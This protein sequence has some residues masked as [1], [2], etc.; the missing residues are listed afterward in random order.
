MKSSEFKEGEWV[1]FIPPQAKGDHR[2][3]DCLRGLV[4]STNDT[5][6]FVRYWTPGLEKWAELGVA[7]DPAQLI[8]LARETT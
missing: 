6:V 7:T 8:K 3:A 2:H 5:W 4:G 1:L